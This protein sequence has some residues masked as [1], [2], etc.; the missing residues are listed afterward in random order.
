MVKAYVHRWD[1]KS[2]GIGRGWVEEATQ[3]L[4]GVDKTVSKVGLLAAIAPYQV[5]EE[6]IR[7]FKSYYD[8]DACLLNIVSWASFTASRR[9]GS[10]L[11][12]R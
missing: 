11:S 3:S 12:Y 8:K 4:T 10:W 9:I 2:P 7:E 1:G 6:L 5:D